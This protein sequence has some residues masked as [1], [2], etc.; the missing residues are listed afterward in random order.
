MSSVSLLLALLA[1]GL[2]A[3]FLNAFAAA[4]N[5]GLGELDDGAYIAA[6]QSINDAIPNGV[7]VISFVGAPL[8]LVL[9]TALHASP[10]GPRLAPLLLAGALVVGGGLLITFV[11]NV[12]LND[13]LAAVYPDARREVL[14]QA[15][16]D[17]EDPWNTWN[18]VRTVACTAA[19]A[20]LGWALRLPAERPG[21]PRH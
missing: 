1:T 3:G 17:Y 18:A 15:R 4:V 20:C 14:A 2:L 11:A 21:G 19:L 8:L 13:E 10:P 6:M 7:F 12:P 16:A 5:F 9:T